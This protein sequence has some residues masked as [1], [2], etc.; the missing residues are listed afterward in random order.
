MEFSR[1]LDV[2]RAFE[3]AKVEYVLVGDV[4]TLVRMKRRTLRPIDQADAV[5]L[6]KMFGIEGD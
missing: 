1:F 6:A 2:V 4:R 3:H 5:A